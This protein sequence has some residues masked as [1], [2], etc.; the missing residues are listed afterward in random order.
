MEDV[1]A[2]L[3]V[4]RPKPAMKAVVE[5]VPFTL[6]LSPYGVQPDGSAVVD[7]MSKTYGQIVHRLFRPNKGDEF[8]HFGWNAWSS[9]VSPLTGHAFRQHRDLMHFGDHMRAKRLP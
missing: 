1:G 8:R 5:S 6:L 2:C 9:S 4:A 7:P 3:G